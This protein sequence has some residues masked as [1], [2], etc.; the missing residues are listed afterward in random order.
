MAEGM[1]ITFED[2][3]FNAALDEL[4]E[5]S[6]RT[7]VEVLTGQARSLL[8]AL[9][10]GTPLT[11]EP[12]R[13]EAGRARA[14]WFVSW[15]RLG[16]RG[17]PSGTTGRVLAVPEGDFNDGRARRNRPFVELIN[18]VPYIDKLERKHQILQTATTARFD[19][20]QREISR[21]YRLNMARKSGRG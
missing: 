11:K 15:F 7:D 18:E 20:M 14:G 6:S 5:D 12:G 8:R 9:V 16:M 10:W 4:A 13:T 17:I 19:D 3:E 21:R 2:R 1:S